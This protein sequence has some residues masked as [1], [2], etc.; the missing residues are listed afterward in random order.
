MY[1]NNS[2]WKRQQNY[3]IKNDIKGYTIIFLIQVLKSLIILSLFYLICY[4][5]LLYLY[6]LLIRLTILQTLL[7]WKQLRLVDSKLIN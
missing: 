6:Q 3:S 2:T 1:V 4:T 7:N 5:I